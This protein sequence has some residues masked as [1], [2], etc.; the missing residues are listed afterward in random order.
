MARERASERGLLHE[1]ARKRSNRCVRTQEPTG[2]QQQSDHHHPCMAPVTDPLSWMEHEMDMHRHG[3]LL[4]CTG[5][6]AIR[7]GA[8]IGARSTLQE[9]GY[10]HRDN[11]DGDEDVAEVF[12][13]VSL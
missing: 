12:F 8:A 6:M 1:L 2:K 9:V 11:G 4:W 5:L 13:F 10:D 3:Q 7:G